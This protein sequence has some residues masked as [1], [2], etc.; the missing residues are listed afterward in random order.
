[1]TRP[2]PPYKFA[3]FDLDNTLAD[4]EAAVRHLAMQLYKSDLLDQSA[5]SVEEAIDA[6]VM[7]DRDGHAQDKALFFSQVAGAWGP[8]RRSPAE[9]DEWYRTAPRDWYEPDPAVVSFLA[10]MT[11]SDVAWGIITNG[12]AT[13][14]EKTRLMRLD[15]GA[16]CILISD[17]F[18]AE[19][20]DPCCGTSGQARSVGSRD[21]TTGRGLP[22]WER[23]EGQGVCSKEGSE[24][25]GRRG[26]SY[27][28]AGGAGYDSRAR[29]RRT[30]RDSLQEGVRAASDLQPPFEHRGVKDGKP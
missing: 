9:L 13:Q 17:V 6:F 14:L 21:G 12:S 26:F 29:Q 4:R 10:D 27:A 22:K 23:N 24:C 30:D 7:F 18:G 15:T 20:P 11:A 3:L 28:Q 19:K 1:M 25:E 2:G 16:K 8:M 5:L